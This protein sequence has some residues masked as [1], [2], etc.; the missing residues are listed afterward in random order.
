MNKREKGTVYESA[1]STFLEGKGC[2]IIERNYRTRYGEIDIIFR[3][4]EY[5]VFAE[6]KYRSSDRY[7]LPQEAVDARKQ[8]KIRN[9]AGMYIY[10]KHI[11]EDR[12]IRFDVIA[13]LGDKLTH[14]V[15]AF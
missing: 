4:G 2:E 1:A 5:L 14:F 15:N 12:K 11:P 6:V 8:H 10:D 9:M 3:D 13:I 7:G